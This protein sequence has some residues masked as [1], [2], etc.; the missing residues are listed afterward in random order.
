MIIRRIPP[1][2]PF[3]QTPLAKGYQLVANSFPTDH[4][5]V[6]TIC[7]LYARL[8][9]GFVDVHPL[10]WQERHA[11]RL[12]RAT[13]GAG[14]PACP[15]RP[16]V[17]Q[18]GLAHAAPPRKSPTRAAVRGLS[19]AE[20]FEQIQQP[21]PQNDSTPS[22]ASRAIIG[23]RPRCA[24]TTRKAI[25]HEGHQE[26]QGSQECCKKHNGTQNPL[27]WFSCLS[28]FLAFVFFMASWFKH[29]AIRHQWPKNDLDKRPRIRYNRS[30]R[31]QASRPVI[32]GNLEKKQLAISL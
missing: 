12:E 29:S 30:P 4:K 28:W 20:K 14:F 9:R 23:H 6:L 1:R 10:K 24:P 32:F 31:Q 11:R 13:R 8:T 3:R 26:H 17:R 27:S 18:E 7:S 22:K 19:T 25:N 21:H 15:I 5:Q 16:E 2:S